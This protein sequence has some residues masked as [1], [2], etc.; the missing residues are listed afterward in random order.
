MGFG[1]FGYND[2]SNRRV[3]ERDPLDDQIATPPPLRY[4]F[5]VVVTYI[6]TMAAVV[7][8]WGADV[9]DD[10]SKVALGA[11][12]PLLAFSLSTLAFSGSDVLAAWRRRIYSGIALVASAL[13]LGIVLLLVG[14][15]VF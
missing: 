7:V 1:F 9:P 8:A 15:G 3:L 12:L 10:G 4:R 6:A 5:V 14:M 2:R 11:S 13:L